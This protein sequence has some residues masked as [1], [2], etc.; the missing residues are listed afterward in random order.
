V[1]GSIAKAYGV[2]TRE[3]GSIVRTV[4]DKDVT[5]TRGI[6]ASRWTFVIDRNGEIAHIDKEVDAANDSQKVLEVLKKR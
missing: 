5:L 6:T 1:T 3:G 4:N 2:P